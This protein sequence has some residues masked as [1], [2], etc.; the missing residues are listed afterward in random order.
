MTPRL[1]IKRIALSL[2]FVC[3]VLA[4]LG[5]SLAWLATREATLSWLLES[6]LPRSTM[7]LAIEGVHGTV[8]GPFSIH[9]I[10]FENAEQR[11][12][13]NDFTIDWVPRELIHRV[14]RVRYARIRS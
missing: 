14:L 1:L 9:R 2:A 13:V 8:Y 11:I 3:L 12:T 7:G 6:A 5:L 10:R 4:L